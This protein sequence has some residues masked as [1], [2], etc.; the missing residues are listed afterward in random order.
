LKIAIAAGRETCLKAAYCPVCGFTD[1]AEPAWY[2]RN[3]GVQW[4]LQAKEKE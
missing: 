1:F 2:C 4:K 3:C